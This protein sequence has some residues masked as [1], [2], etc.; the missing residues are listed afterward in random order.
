MFPRFSNNDE[1][2]NWLGQEFMNNISNPDNAACLI[3]NLVTTYQNHGFRGINLDIENLS[4]TDTIP[5]VN[6][7]E[8]LT[9][10]F[11]KENMYVTIDLPMNNDVYDYEALSSIVDGVVI[12]AYDEHYIYGEAGSIASNERFKD[13]VSDIL[14][15]VDPKKTIIAIGNYAYD[16]DT[17]QTG[18]AANSMSF[19]DAVTLADD[20][21]ADIQTD[22][23]AI[24]STFN[25]L[26]SNKNIHQVRMLDG[27]SARDE[28]YFTRTKNALGMSLR[29][30]GIEDPSLRKF[31]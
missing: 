19:D 17:A 21:G 3:Q 1:S 29:R 14:K 2:G 6:W 8:D 9:T 27:I 24:N 5:F 23:T 25:Y 13:G 31:R 30:I 26:D 11:H 18:S 4:S 20:I 15:R 28:Y 16:W 22:T 10:A 12:M 7:V